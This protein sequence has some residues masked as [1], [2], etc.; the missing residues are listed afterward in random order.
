MDK[1]SFEAIYGKGTSLFELAWF[2]RELQS[3]SQRGQVLVITAFI[4]DLVE[5]TLREYLP[6]Q[7]STESL[8]SGAMA[9]IGN[10]AAKTALACSLD[11]ITASEYNNIE[12]VRKIRN[13]FAHTV[14]VSF[15]DQ[16][17]VALTNNLTHALADLDKDPKTKP[18]EPFYRFQLVTA[19][20]LLHLHD[21]S[22]KIG[23]SS[24]A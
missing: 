18:K 16:S 12:I 19:A 23:E 9:P 10:L 20:L 13:K 6:K 5:R 14:D 4:E 11:L 2:N 1:D 24:T 21:R 15:M 3:E 22:E 7:T 8:L 17:I